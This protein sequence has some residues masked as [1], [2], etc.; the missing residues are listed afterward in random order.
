MEIIFPIPPEQHLYLE[1][2]TSTLSH[3]LGH[4]SDG[5]ILSA[6]KKKLWAVGL[7]SYLFQTNRDFACFAVNIDLT[8][9]G[10]KNVNEIISCVF[11]YIGNVPL[12]F[13]LLCLC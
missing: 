6:L 4:E 5:S 12:P 2:P 3:L 9:E 13:V 8:E 1:K 10:V 7:S 11:A